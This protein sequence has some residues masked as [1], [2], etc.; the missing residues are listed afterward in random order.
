MGACTAYFLSANMPKSRASPLQMENNPHPHSYISQ[1][2]KPLKLFDRK[3]IQLVCLG[4]VKVVTA[5][6]SIH[7]H[8][9]LGSNNGLG[10]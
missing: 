7:L 9:N 5:P 4:F 2:F 10:V 8:A 1:S 6:L 3:I